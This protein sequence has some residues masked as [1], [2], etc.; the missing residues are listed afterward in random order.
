M[1][2]NNRCTGATSVTFKAN[3]VRLG[4]R[5]DDMNR[6]KSRDRVWTDVKHLI[7]PH[8]ATEVQKL[9]TCYYCLHN[10]ILLY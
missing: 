10:L 5:K 2:K 8:S 1:R 4:V 9:L 7:Y 3:T 6:V